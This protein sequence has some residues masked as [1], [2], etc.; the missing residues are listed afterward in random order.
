MAVSNFDDYGQDPFSGDARIYGA[1]GYTAAAVEILTPWLTSEW[2]GGLRRIDGVP[3]EV[4]E[5]IATQ[6]LP[7]TLTE[8]LMENYPP[9][10]ELIAV[11]VTLPDAHLHGYIVEEDRGDERV[12]LDG[13]CW[14]G[15]RK[16]AAALLKKYRPA[17]AGPE[18]G[19]FK[20]WWHH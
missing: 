15:T 18:S 4:A 7:T 1:R 17:S 5:H 10:L 14:H 20:V 2:S 3:A 6:H 12:T 8:E 13:L 11:A 16:D 9:M 19:W